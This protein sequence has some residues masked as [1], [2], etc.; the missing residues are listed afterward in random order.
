MIRFRNLT[1]SYG[2]NRGLLDL[3]FEIF[4][5]EVFGLLGPKGSGKTALFSQMM[6]FCSPGRGWCAINGK[7]CYD[8]Q[9]DVQRLVGYLPENPEFPSAMS[10]MQLLRFSAS[11]R[12]IRSLE[13][14]IRAAEKLELNLDEKIHFMSR[15]EKQRLGIAS[16]LVHNPK[17]LLLDEPA[18]E[19]EP[20]MRHHLT[21]LIQEEKAEGKTVVWG[22]R[23]FEDMDRCCDRV[24]ML[25]D[26]SLINVDDI[27][28]I[29]RE[30][31]KAYL[32]TFE[33]DKEA[34]RFGREN[35]EIRSMYASQ[36][37]VVVTGDLTPL[38]QILGAYHVMGFEGVNQ[39]LED[40]FMHFYGG[41]IHA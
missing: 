23:S 16:A 31:R 29:R 28:S 19:L 3:S 5:G 6:G 9:K 33:S 32:I 22:S 18:K 11:V 39:S 30:R 14:G 21:E 35:V 17:V 12:G 27:S 36:V 40:V 26:G 1:K 15:S 37:T 38:I 24:G 8:H 20:A 2:R 13:K 34:V 25:K 10:G 41:G 7:N 4:E